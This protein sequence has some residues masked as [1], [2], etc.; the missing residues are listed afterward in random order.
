MQCR[1]REKDHTKERVREEKTKEP[2]QSQ[3]ISKPDLSLSLPFTIAIPC[4]NLPSL[5]AVIDFPQTKSPHL[6]K[7][8]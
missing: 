6:E 3:S 8:L 5:N 7:M 4:I 1:S 2:A